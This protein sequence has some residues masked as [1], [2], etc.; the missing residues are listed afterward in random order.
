[1]SEGGQGRP[2][3]AR[4]GSLDGPAVMVRT[5][6]CEARAGFAVAPPGGGD[7]CAVVSRSSRCEGQAGHAR[8]LGHVFAGPRCRVRAWSDA[9]QPAVLNHI[10]PTRRKGVMP[11]Y[12][13]A[14][15]LR[16]S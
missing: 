6:G 8:L 3:A 16:P 15:W 5:M 12:E 10:L 1:M 7:A 2:E 4:R 13:H 11:L 9:A 14:C